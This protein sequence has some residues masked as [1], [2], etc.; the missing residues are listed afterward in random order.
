MSG[1]IFL[2]FLESLVNRHKC[3]TLLAVS[4]D[5][6][7]PEQRSYTPLC[8]YNIGLRDLDW[9]LWYYQK[10]KQSRAKEEICESEFVLLMT[11]F[12][13]LSFPPSI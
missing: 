6:P 8:L 2:H 12:T 7:K 9:G 13:L 3:Q 5:H 11:N 1:L 4:W 10:Q